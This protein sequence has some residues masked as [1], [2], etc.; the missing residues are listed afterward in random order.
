MF[1]ITLM[2][3]IYNYIPEKNHVS[4]VYSVAAALYLQFVLHLILFRILNMFLYFYISTFR[5]MCAVSNMAVFCSSVMSCYPCMLLRY[6]LGDFK[7]VPVSPVITDIN[8][9]FTFHMQWISIVLL[10]LLCICP[11]Y[12][13]VKYFNC[14]IYVTWGSIRLFLLQ[15]C[16]KNHWHYVALIMLFERTNTTMGRN[17]WVAKLMELQFYGMSGKATTEKLR[18]EYLNGEI[19]SSFCNQ[20]ASIC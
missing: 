10:L 6:C 12:T 5:S 15:A 17:N 16:E 20:V 9:S 13:F 1:V 14:I 18:W 11:R 8:F 7:M 2:Q 19:L 4:G 3:G